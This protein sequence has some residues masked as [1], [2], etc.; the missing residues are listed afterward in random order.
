MQHYSFHWKENNTNKKQKELEKMNK[1]EIK[2]L[3]GYI[4]WN[5]LLLMGIML[6]IIGGVTNLTAV[7]I[8]G[9]KM[10]VIVSEH[11]YY[12]YSWTSQI[13][14]VTTNESEVQRPFLADRFKI[15]N[16]VYSIG[17]AFIYLGVFTSLVSLV[18]SLWY[19]V[20]IG[21]WLKK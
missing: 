10:P 14:F 17:D 9:G 15:K 13:H 7:S 12:A 19:S 3:M 1:E 4:Q 20:K 18:F 21:K 8:N 2:L 5:K 16:S 6:F 11:D